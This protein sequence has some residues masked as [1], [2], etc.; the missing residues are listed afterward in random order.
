MSSN[1]PKQQLGA[2]LSHF[3]P[4]ITFRRGLSWRHW[5]G[6]VFDRAGDRHFDKKFG[7][8]SSERRSLAQLGFD[9]PD[10]VDYQA[11]SYRDL[12]KL[13][14]S[15]PIGPRDVFLDFGSGMGRAL[16]L[17]AQHPLRSVIGVEL[18]PELCEIARRN[19]D[20][21]KAKLQCQDVQI[22]N[23][24]AIAYKVP[25]DVSIVYF[26]NPFAGDVMTQ[27]LDNIVRSLQAAPRRLLLLFYGTASSEAFREQAK[28]NRW[29][30]LRSELVLPTG[31]MGLIYVNAEWTG[32][33]RSAI[34]RSGSDSIG[35]TQ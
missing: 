3:I 10:Y 34:S 18:S 21:V 31:A 4:E 6:W 19:I 27:V 20:A 16:C 23:S 5:L 9:L 13:L 2:A 14:A 29:L 11:V 7:I 1:G 22:V 26:F 28:M 25:S 35:V 30:A 12:R 32:E 24:N 8:R 33:E 17:A 15:I